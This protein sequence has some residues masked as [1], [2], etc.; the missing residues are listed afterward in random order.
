MGTKFLVTN[1]VY[2]CLKYYKLIVPFNFIVATTQKIMN[3]T[4][5]ILFL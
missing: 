2:F 5:R 3:L 4:L 1:L